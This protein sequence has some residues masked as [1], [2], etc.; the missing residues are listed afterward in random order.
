MDITEAVQKL[1]ALAQDRR[2]QAFRVLVQSGENGLPAGDVARAL[3]VPHNTMSSHLGILENA[4][5]IGS[6]REGRSV[7]YGARFEGARSLLAFLMQDCCRG[8]PEI[9]SPV[10]ATLARGGVPADERGE[11]NET[12]AR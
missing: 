8:L 3:G 11:R 2:L 9:C 7:I 10:L 5:L 6:R 12:P 4:G 1:A